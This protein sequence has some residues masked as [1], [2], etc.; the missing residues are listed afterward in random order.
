VSNVKQKIHIT[1]TQNLN[2]SHPVCNQEFK[3]VPGL[4]SNGASV[5]NT[6]K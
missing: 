3:V 2:F 6:G 1:A 5:P 4:T